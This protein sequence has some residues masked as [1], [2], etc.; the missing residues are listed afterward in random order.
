MVFLVVMVLL[1]LGLGLPIALALSVGPILFIALTGVAPLTVVPQQLI[2]GANTE[3]FLAVPFFMLAGTLME[4]SG[5]S[6]RLV[7]FANYVVG[8]VRGG[9]GI[10]DIVASIIFAGVSGSAAADTAAIGSAIIPGLLKSGYERPA[11]AS[12]Q[13]AAGSMGMLFPPSVVMI[14][15]GTVIGVSIARLFAASIIPGLLMG[16]S[17][18]IVVHVLARRRG[19]P[20]GPRP[21]L[22]SGLLVLRESI[23][24][25]MAPAVIVVGLLAGVFTPTEAGVVASVYVLVIGMFVYRELKPSDLPRVMLMAVERTAT[26]LL[27]VGASSLLGWVFVEEEAAGAIAG[28]IT[29]LSHNPLVVMI[30]IALILVVVHFFI[31]HT[32][33]IVAV[34]PLFLPLVSE[35]NIDKVYFA[36]MVL[37]NSALAQI[38]PPIGLTLLTASSIAGVRIEQMA[39]PVLP[40]VIVAVVDLLLVIFFPE[41][42]LALPRLLFH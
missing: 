38:T 29:G 28:G 20:C 42:S 19:Y 35:L 18:M 21:D 39:R 3:S 34:V 30:L 25:L 12:L 24:A 1:S 17:Y 16:V 13:A 22:R 11:A 4:A 26:V 10:A 31:E 37:I 32:P 23:L 14:I 8:W 5:T 36:M 15:M 41:L 2:Y 40:F 27:V 33:T 9:L 7:A 6:R